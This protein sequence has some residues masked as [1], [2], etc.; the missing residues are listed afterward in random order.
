V[1]FWQ[2]LLVLTFKGNYIISS[3]CLL[4]TYILLFFL[5]AFIINQIM[6]YLF[7]VRCYA[8]LYI[9]LTCMCIVY[10][11]TTPDIFLQEFVTV[12]LLLSTKNKETQ[13]FTGLCRRYSKM[14]CYIWKNEFRRKKQYRHVSLLSYWHSGFTFPG[15]FLPKVELKSCWV[16][17]SF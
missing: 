10:L 1:Y 11:W 13:L 7:W 15:S 6:M 17:W 8:K 3:D 14:W 16:L 4:H 12:F 2:E 9:L 5:H